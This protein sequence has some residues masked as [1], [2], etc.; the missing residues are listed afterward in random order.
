M[1]LDAEAPFLSGTQFASIVTSRRSSR[2][3]RRLAS[4]SN[5]FGLQLRKAEVSRRRITNGIRSPL[6][7][8]WRYAPLL[9][10]NIDSI[11]AV[12]TSLLNHA[13][14]KG[15]CDNLPKRRY[16]HRR[17]LSRCTL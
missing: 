4:R 17:G 3:G 7:M 16:G 14:L 5:G 13:Y 12:A 11:D 2:A 10:P 15:A 6:L 1:Q 9:F 8:P